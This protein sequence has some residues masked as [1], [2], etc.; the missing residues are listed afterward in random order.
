M[1]LTFADNLGVN[2][3]LLP[4]GRGDDGAQCVSCR[5]YIH[6]AEA[7]IGM[8]YSSTN[9]KLDLSNYLNGV[10]LSLLRNFCFC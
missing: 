9:E 2:V 5:D 4:M 1:T 7:D 3:L 10:R 8:C 6:G